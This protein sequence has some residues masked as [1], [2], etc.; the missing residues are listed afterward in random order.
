M[1][2]SKWI[3]VLY[4]IS[5]KTDLRIE[6]YVEDVEIWRKISLCASV[7]SQILTIIVPG[8]SVRYIHIY[9]ILGNSKA[10][11]R[12]SC[13]P[14]RAMSRKHGALIAERL[15]ARLIGEMQMRAYA[16]HLEVKLS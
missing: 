4:Y 12:K 6:D 14:Y 13:I 2:N 15:S 5:D 1:F 11:P 8:G 9:E 10:T 7:A 3:V 16:A